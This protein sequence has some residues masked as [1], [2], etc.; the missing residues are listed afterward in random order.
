MNRSFLPSFCLLCVSVSLWFLL[1]PGTLHAADE[2]TPTVGLPARIDGLVL[3]GSELEVKP[4]ADRRAPLILRIV[5]VWPH[6]TAFRYDLEYYG[7]EAGRFDLKEV[8]RRKDGSSSAGLPAIP[9]TIRSVL[10]PGQVKPNELEPKAGPALGGYRVA[11]FAAGGLWL[12]G[13][14][15]I[16]VVG[17]RKKKEEE[18]AAGKPRTLADHLR[19][20]VEGAV[21]GR[22]AAPQLAEL[23]RSLLVYW[24]RRLE[25]RDRKPAQ[26]IAELRRHPQAGPLLQQLE[27][28]LHRPGT[29]SDI[30]VAALLEPYRDLPADAVAFGVQTS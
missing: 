17:R 6:G 15:A 21:A 24:E 27:I 2:R 19:P 23:E 18:H 25:L 1:G 9:V 7:L 8:L 29:A 13:L 20:L 10:P 4:L 12:L 22:L 14:V 11:L 5:Q 16:V 30:D 3:P 28:W 26:A